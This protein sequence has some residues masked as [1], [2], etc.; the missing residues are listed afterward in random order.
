MN[1]LFLLTQ[2]YPDFQ[3]YLEVALIGLIIALIGAGGFVFFLSSMKDDRADRIRR[4]LTD[5]NP[6]GRMIGQEA[7]EAPKS[8]GKRKSKIW[9]L[10]LM[11]IVLLLVFLLLAIK[12]SWFGI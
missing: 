11:A 7:V 10:P 12:N 9:M 4:K 8:K 2:I 6:W 3:I 1:E 5:Q